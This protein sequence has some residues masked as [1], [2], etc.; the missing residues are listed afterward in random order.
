[1]KIT[2]GQSVA[3]KRKSESRIPSSKIKMKSMKQLR[4]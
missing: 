1:M 3:M 4:P 2:S